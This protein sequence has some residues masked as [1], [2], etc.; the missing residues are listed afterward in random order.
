MGK[1]FKQ[2]IGIIVGILGAP[3]T[4]AIIMTLS[5]S[6]YACEGSTLCHEIRRGIALAIGLASAFIAAR[7]VHRSVNGESLS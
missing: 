5:S 3:V 1:W 2:N 7:I 4:T 6:I